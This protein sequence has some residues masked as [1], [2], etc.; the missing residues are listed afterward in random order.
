MFSFQESVQFEVVLMVLFAGMTILRD[1]ML[2][3]SYSPCTSQ[4][5]FTMM[6]F[7]LDIKWYNFKPEYFQLWFFTKVICAF[8]LQ[9]KINVVF[10]LKIPENYA[11]SLLPK[12]EPKGHFFLPHILKNFLLRPKMTNFDTYMTQANMRL[13]TCNLKK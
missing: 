2:Y 4:A 7:K 5:W 3:L 12:K 9:E 11:S 13:D 8:V 6:P 1:C 10:I